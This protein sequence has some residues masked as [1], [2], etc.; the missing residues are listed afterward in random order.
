[1]ADWLCFMHG[2]TSDLLIMCGCW[3]GMQQGLDFTVLGL[4]TN[5]QLQ[6]QDVKNMNEPVDVHHMIVDADEEGLA[7]VGVGSG[8]GVKLCV[9]K[10]SR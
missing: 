3:Q 5:N 6:M 7:C 2:F 10:F 1:M 9:S 8:G 4:H